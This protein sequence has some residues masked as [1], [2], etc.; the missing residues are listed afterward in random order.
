MRPAF[1]HALA[2][3]SQLSDLT[4]HT[5]LN[6]HYIGGFCL[7]ALKMYK[8]AED[9]FEIAVCAP[10]QGPPAGLQLEAL[11]KLALVQLILYGKVRWQHSPYSLHAPRSLAQVLSPPKYTHPALL[12]AF[13]G[14]P[15]AGLSRVFS[16]PAAATELVAKEARAFSADQNL[17]LVRV[18][19]ARAPRWAARALTATYATLALGEL[20]R[21]VGLESEDAVR[22]LVLSMVRCALL[23]RY[24][25]DANHR[26][27]HRS[28]RARC[29]PR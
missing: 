25:R 15:Y 5:S 24:E 3:P 10:A 16:T 13:K 18:A 1:F 28:R 11:N 6:Y 7:T 4:Y 9:F 21:A 27:A 20:G 26:M 19:L 29:T 8:E 14:S 23:T 17:G 12:R 2:E 22:A